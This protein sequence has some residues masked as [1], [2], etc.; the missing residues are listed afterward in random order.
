MVR[1]HM[2][3]DA[4]SSE[5]IKAQ[6][7][8]IIVRPNR[9]LL[10]T[11]SRIGLM[12]CLVL[13]TTVGLAKADAR[14][15][16]GHLRSACLTPK[17]PAPPADW[18]HEKG[19]KE[20]EDE[21]RALLDDRT[22]L[23]DAE[24]RMSYLHVSWIDPLLRQADRQLTWTLESRRLIC[25]YYGKGHP[26]CVQADEQVWQADNWRQIVLDSRY[27]AQPIAEAAARMR[28]ACRGEEGDKALRAK[29]DK[30]LLEGKRKVAKGGAYVRRP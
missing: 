19:C 26:D 22:S 1:P 25:A 10:A 23:A 21:L 12:A 27:V 2:F 29:Y 7:T 9:S 6:L 14:S 13:A 28:D 15:G 17:K 24:K 3:K 16:P 4:S 11:N 8:R 5:V 20:A 30:V 18:R